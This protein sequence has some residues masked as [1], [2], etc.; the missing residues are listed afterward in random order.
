MSVKWQGLGRGIRAILF[1]DCIAINEKYGCCCYTVTKSVNAGWN[2]KYHDG[3][4]D[5]A[6]LVML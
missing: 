4:K 2:Y 6:A 3:R 1:T 5:N